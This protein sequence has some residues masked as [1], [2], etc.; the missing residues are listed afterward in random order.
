MVLSMTGYGK[1]TSEF[2]GKKISVEIRSLNSKQ[3]DINV[4]VPQF[5]RSKELEIRDMLAKNLV[6]GKIDFNLF[7][8]ITGE[9]EAPKV[10]KP[11]VLGYLQ[12]LGE[13]KSEASVDSDTLAIA[14]R[15]PDVLKSEK[16]ELTDDEWAQIQSVIKQAIT[17]MQAFR[18]QEGESLLADFTGRI[19]AIRTH[20]QQVQPFEESRITSLKERLQKNLENIEVDKDRFEQELIFYLEKLDINEEKVRLANHLDYFLE[21]MQKEEN[22]GKKLGF[23]SQEIG[24]EINTLGSKANQADIQKLVVQMKEELERIKEQVLNTL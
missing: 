3:T 19:N 20:L 21:V 9:D 11:I 14:M 18:Q 12:Q 6:R 7:A 13:I 22:C 24:R 1:A 4:R 8:E 5:Y 10:N 16:E 2:P 15:M 17:H 23:I